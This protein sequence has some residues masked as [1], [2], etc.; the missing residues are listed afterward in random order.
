MRDKSGFTLVEMMV[1]IAV[2]GVLTAIAIPNYIAWLPKFRANS[3][4]R[5]LFTDLQ[6]AR[7]R[8]I[9][10]NNYYVIAFDTGANSYSIYDDDESD[11]IDVGVESGEL[12]KTV[13]INDQHP[14]IEFGRIGG[15]DVTF[16]GTPKRVIFAPTGRTKSANGTAYFIPTRDLSDNRTDRQRKITVISTGR[17]QLYK[18]NGSTWE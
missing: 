4:A 15:S 9:S 10:E 8:A 5:Q 14:G 16:S 13:N 11:F 2:L 18:H 17:I 3:A 6:Y 1:V 7:M 12:V